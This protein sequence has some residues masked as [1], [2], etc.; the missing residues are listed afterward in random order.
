MISEYRLGNVFGKLLPHASCLMPCYCIDFGK[1]SEPRLNSYDSSN[2]LV[3][4]V[5]V[6]VDPSFIK[7][8]VIMLVNC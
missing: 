5:I 2:A 7:S 6:L 8:V 3:P 4:V 1:S